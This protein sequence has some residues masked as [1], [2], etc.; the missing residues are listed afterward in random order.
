MAAI[1]ARAP[2]GFGAK[3][4]KYRYDVIF[5]KAPLTAP[6]GHGGRPPKAG[7]RSRRGRAPACCILA[8]DQQ[9]DAEPAARV[10]SLPIYKSMTIR[11]WRTTT[12]CSR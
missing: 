8:A 9:G 3:P 12:R 2:K 5:L 1:V 4:E 11:N 6:D 7:R 10:V